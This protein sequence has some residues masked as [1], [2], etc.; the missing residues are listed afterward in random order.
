MGRRDCSFMGNGL[1]LSNLAISPRIGAHGLDRLRFR[2]D[3]L[4]QEWPTEQ[5]REDTE[6]KQACH[7]RYK[8]DDCQDGS[9]NPMDYRKTK[10]DQGKAS[11]NAQKTTIR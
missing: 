10:D 9:T 3:I 1:M 5:G 11:H 2:L 7:Q 4:C 6:I 8:T